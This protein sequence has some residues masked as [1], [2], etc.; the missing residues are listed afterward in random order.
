MRTSAPPR[1]LFPQFGYLLKRVAVLG[2]YNTQY[3]S[4]VLRAC[5]YQRK[6][7]PEYFEAGY[8]LLEASIYSNA[9]ALMQFQPE[10]IYFCVGTEHLQWGDFDAELARW[11]NLWTASSIR[12]DTGT[13]CSPHN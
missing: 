4:P 11:V 2:G 13:R 5:L 10:I 3:L 9:P 12:T 7:R 6:I 8:G 1:D